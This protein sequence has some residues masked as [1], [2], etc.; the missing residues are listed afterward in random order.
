MSVVSCGRVGER[1]DVTAGGAA[2][3]AWSSKSSAKTA[4]MERKDECVVSAEEGG[5]G[6]VVTAGAEFRRKIGYAEVFGLGVNV[7]CR[8]VVSAK[9]CIVAASSLR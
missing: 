7:V 6:P 2:R 9:V 8:A 4:L 3:G 5:A 1:T